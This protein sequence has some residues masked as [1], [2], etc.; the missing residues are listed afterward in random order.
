MNV[1]GHAAVAVAVGT[2]SPSF[3][4]GAVL[5]D[6]A[7]MARVRLGG[8]APPGDV[9]DGVRCHH[10][11]DT[12]FH[13]LPSF[14][15]G[16]ASLRSDLLASG[17]A[18]GPARA[19]G[20]AG[21]ELLLDGALVGGD[22]ESAY[23][24]ALAEGAAAVDAVQPGDRARW[25]AFVARWSDAPALRYD[26]PAWVAERLFRMLGHRPRLRLPVEQVPAVV[27]ALERHAAGVRSAAPAVLDAVRDRMAA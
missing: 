11:A 5:P 8:S 6:L 7:S 26:Q 17:L 24:A 25:L 22:A 14:R 18:T 23:R 4:L 12:A 15:A 19:I 27:D 16:A 21:W 3:V 10:A 2:G 1:L 20:H 9:T 13:A